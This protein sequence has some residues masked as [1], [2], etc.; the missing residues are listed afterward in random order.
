MNNKTI[1]EEIMIKAA[2]ARKLA[3]YMSSTQDL[4]EEQIQKAFQ[5]GDFDNLEGAGKPLNLYE[6]P[7][8]PPELRMVFKILKDNNFAPYWI[9]LGKEIDADLD[10]FEKEVE[11][12][13]KYTRIFVSEKHN[14]KS[15]KRF[16]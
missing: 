7:Y 15:I 11:H 10:K 1:Q 4:V 9:E 14:Q 3:K 16:E 2:Q 5:R 6:N 8:E 12:F 13:K